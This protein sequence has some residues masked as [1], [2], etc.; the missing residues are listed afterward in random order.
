MNN[1]Y[2]N[3]QVSKEI[4]NSAQKFTKH[5]SKPHQSNFREIIRG[6][7]TNKTCF[8]SQIAKSNSNTN[9]VRKDVER[10]SKTLSKIPADKFQ[11]IHINSHISQ[12]KNE[13]V[14]LLSDGGDFQ[15][16]YAKKMEYICKNV[17][18]SNGHKTGKGFSI[19]SVVA[20]GVKT[21]NIA[22]LACHVFSTQKEDYKSDWE[23][24][25]KIF[26]MCS[27]LIESSPYDRIIV[28][29]RGC[30]DEKRFMYFIKE[31]KCSFI[32]RICAGKK[33]RNVIIKD[34]DKNEITV[35]I[36]SL[37]RTLKN[38]A[39]SKRKWFNKKTKKELISKI[40]YQK[41]FLPKH[42]NIPL[43]AIFVYSENYD[44]PLVVF[45][46]LITDSAEKAWK[47]FFY[48]KKRWEVENFYRAIKQNHDAEKFLILKFVKIQALTF[49][50]MLVTSLILKI[51]QKAQEFFGIIYSLFKC[52]CKKEQ[53][54]SNHYLDV[55]AFLR[56]YIPKVI[57]G[58]SYKFYSCYFS[59]NRCYSNCQQLKLFDFRKKW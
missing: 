7:L 19:E 51:K 3:T 12:F 43:Y 29:D 33:A 14:L 9:N 13:P 59:K 6:L 35:S 24:H 42:K 26:N 22:P 36:Q 32:T 10:Y 54:T 38:K 30:D 23:E 25:K 27:P 16:P 45:T 46:D 52:F 2:L 28:E 21:K 37:A 1:L 11:Q 55:L 40:S 49:L 5:L 39:K 44:E 4:F 57:D 17:D 48:Y 50:F 41:V 8:L 18:G 15:K 31:L 53:R 58:Y 56:T 47:H 34:E 20:Y